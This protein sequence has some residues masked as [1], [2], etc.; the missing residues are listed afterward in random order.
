MASIDGK[1]GHHRLGDDGIIDLVG[2]AHDQAGRRHQAGF[3]GPRQ[4]LLRAACLLLNY[5]ALGWL[6]HLPCI[7]FDQCDSII[8]Q[9]DR[10]PRVDLT[11]RGRRKDLVADIRFNGLVE[12]HE[13]IWTAAQV[14]HGMIWRNPR[15][16]DNDIVI[17]VAAKLNELPMGF[18][19]IKEDL[20]AVFD[21]LEFLVSSHAIFEESCSLQ[22]I[23]R[24]G[25]SP[26]RIG[27]PRF[28]RQAANRG[29]QS[30]VVCSCLGTGY[31]EFHLKMVAKV[32]EPFVCGYVFS[33]ERIAEH[34][35]CVNDF[36]R[37]L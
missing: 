7:T 20:A 17:G 12:L 1:F 19:F 24:A 11:C 15:A 31:L 10:V 25:H 33:Y 8:A 9:L 36:T 4:S 37:L 14:Q 32:G 3:A 35:G 5:W 29:H 34:T 18:N 2:R 13:L 30:G 26:G 28:A 27:V 23:G 22:T 6:A 21:Y 16:G